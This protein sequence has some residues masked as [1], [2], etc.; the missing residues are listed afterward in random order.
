M[1][2][3]VILGVAVLDV[4]EGVYLAFGLEA[5]AVRRSTNHLERI[6]DP[7]IVSLLE[8]VRR[9]QVRRMWEL[10]GVIRRLEEGEDA[11]I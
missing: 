10:E 6:D 8:G 3:I 9:A 11:G 2:V 5:E 4:L 1:A 7:A